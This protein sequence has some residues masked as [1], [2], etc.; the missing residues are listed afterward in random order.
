MAA[1]KTRSLKH[2]SLSDRDFEAISEGEE[3]KCA[4]DIW[5]Y[6]ESHKDEVEDVEEYA[7][8][9]KIIP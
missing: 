3:T 2:S 9:R 5:A 6:Y 7:R 1:S 4:D 8:K